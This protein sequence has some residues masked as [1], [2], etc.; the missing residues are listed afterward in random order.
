VNVVRW[1]ERTLAGARARSAAFD[2]AWRAKQRYD[3]V[4][5]GRLAAATAYYGFFAVFALGLVSYAILGYLVASDSELQRSVDAFLEQNLPFL[6]VESLASGRRTVGIIGLVSLVLTGAGWVESMR[7]SQRAVWDLDQQPGTVVI[8][9]LVDLGMLVGLGLLLALSLTVAD[10]VQ[11]LLW[12]MAPD[13]VSPLWQDALRLAGPI[14][15]FGVNLV[16]AAAAL[17]GLPRLRIP[18]RRLVPSLLLLA[19]GTTLLTTIGRY[20][21]ARTESNPAYTVVAGTA[22]ALLF[23]FFFGQLVLFSSALAATGTHGTVVDLAAGPP[24]AD[25]D[26]ADEIAD[27]GRNA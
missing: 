1:Y 23:L 27:S 10:G 9:R 3:E 22:G 26:D 11:N 19:V 14:V 25:P 13:S 5:G 20:Y 17:A 2:H 8:R 12:W 6:N 24:D 4:Q 21:I 16:L 15:G 18:F 7:T